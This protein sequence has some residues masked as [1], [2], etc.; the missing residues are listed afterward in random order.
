MKK[1]K[2][3]LFIDTYFPLIDGVIMVVDNYAKELSKYAEVVV[4]VP[5][6]TKDYDDKIHPYKIIRIKSIKVPTTEYHLATPIVDIKVTDELKMENF[7]IIHIHS[8]FAIGRLGI[9]LAKKLNIPVVI[10]SHTQFKYEFEKYTKFSLAVDVMMKYIMNTFNKCNNCFVVNKRMLDVIKEYGYKNNLTVINN[11][12]DMMPVKDKN[13][14]CN[15]IN[16]MYNLKDNDFVLLFV[17][18]INA[19]KNIFFII[20][21]FKILKKYNYNFKLLFVGN[22]PDLEKLKAKIKE[23]NLNNDVILCGEIKNRTMLANIYARSNLFVFPS[24]FD[25]SSLVQIE[26]ASQ[27]TPSI[28]IKGSVTANTVSDDINGFLAENDKECFANKIITIYENKALYEKVSNRAYKDLYINWK[29]TAKI[30]YKNYLK[31][32]NEYKKN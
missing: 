19:V 29:Q 4:V 30:V 26:A 18:R 8:P 20:D 16:K 3:G 7:D 25:T 27:K 9:K 11:A 28:L 1:I 31:I 23:N 21:V 5:S 17:G 2:I 13:L 32:I 14:S 15:I 24:M 12:T 22:G 10:T 6:I